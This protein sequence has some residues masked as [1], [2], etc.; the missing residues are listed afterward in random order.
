MRK[1]KLQN[2]ITVNAIAGTYVVFLGFDLELKFR[3]EFRG[4]AIKRKDHSDGEE[5]WLRGIKTF[6][7]TNPHPAPGET[8]SSFYHPIQGFQWADYSA[9]SGITYTYTIVC[10]YGNPSNLQNKREIEITITTEVE[11]GNIHTVFF[12]RGSVASQEY[13]RKFLNKKPSEAGIG[14]YKW[15]SRGLVEALIAFIERANKDFSIHGAVYELQFPEVLNALKQASNRGANVKVIFD[16]VEKYNSKGKPIGPWKR[17]RE[18]IKTSKIK[19]LCISR[20]HGK[21]MHNKF[22]VLSKGNKNLAVWTG[23]TNLTENGIYGHSNLGHIVENEAVANSYIDYWKRLKNDPVIDNVYRNANMSASPIPSEMQNGTA[24]IFSP[25]GN[26]L[27]ALNWYAHIAEN[28]QNAL[29]MTFAFGMHE[30]FKKIFK[31]KDNILRMALMEK[32]YSSPRIKE[33]DEKEIQK[34][35]NLSNVIVSIGNRIVTNSFDRWLIEIDRIVNNIHVHWIHTKYMLV[36]PLGNAP[37]VISGSAN[38]SKASTNTN[39]ENMMIIKGDKRIADIYFGEYI[40][41]FSHYSFREAVKWAMKK[42]NLGLPQQ[43]TPQYLVNDD[44]WMK[45]YF[46]EVDD[47]TA[48]CARRKYFAGQMSI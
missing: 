10:M 3:N 48:R 15:L 43:W 6:K 18:Q 16:D 38:F 41:L 40:R 30:K 8:F 1:R 4:F 27:D 37:I 9:K 34:I 39:D 11:L 26:N 28:A 21:L 25:R 35:R 17:N 32:A 22:F 29:F 44:N 12:N 7:E 5:I 2:G 13:A 24:L 31:K 33:K 20:A 45:D 36:D 23:S 47:R 46:E 14:A 19:S 42:N